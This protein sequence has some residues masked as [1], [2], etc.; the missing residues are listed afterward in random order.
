VW[1]EWLRALIGEIAFL[2]G[3]MASCT[4]IHNMLL[5]DPDLLD[6]TLKAPL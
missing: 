6:A 4:A 5:R 2:K 3:Y 1:A